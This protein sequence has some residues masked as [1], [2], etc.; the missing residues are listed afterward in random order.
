MRS[1][2]KSIIL[3]SLLICICLGCNKDVQQLTQYETEQNA[4]KEI[5]K[6]VGSSV[7]IEVYK[8]LTLTKNRDSQTISNYYTSDSILS[9]NL[10]EFKKFYQNLK[11][12]IILVRFPINE[13]IQ[14]YKTNEFDGPRRPGK[15]GEHRQSFYTPYMLQGS[16]P[17]SILPT[18]NIIYNTDESGRVIGQPS[19]YFTGINIF[20]WTQH[21]TNPTFNFNPNTL[22]TTF[23]V[24]GTTLYGI[25]FGGLNL[26]VSLGNSYK[27]TVHMDSVFG[28]NGWVD[29]ISSTDGMK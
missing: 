8:D 29:I 27:I 1:S 6:I 3:F 13:A 14:L 22:T 10:E 2:K 26:G 9:F 19:I 23:I 20:P 24:T 17:S 15:A 25:S 28:Q 21:T 4:I 16:S 7:S 5:R 11:D 12:T 18:L